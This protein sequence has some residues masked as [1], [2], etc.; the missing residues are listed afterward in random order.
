MTPQPG[1]LTIAIH[2]LPNISGGKGN[3][4]M[5]FGQLI[6]YNLRNTFLEK[7]YGKCR[8]ETISRKSKIQLISASII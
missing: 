8:G 4:T 7:T 1:K 3:E 6:E 2:I 5:K